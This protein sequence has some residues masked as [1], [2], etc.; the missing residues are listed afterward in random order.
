MRN[1]IK[2][3]IIF[4]F[5]I[6]VF[7]LFKSLYSEHSVVIKDEKLTWN[8]KYKGIEGAKEIAS[9]EKGNFY[10][11]YTDRIQ[12]VDGNGKSFDIIK[13]KD[14]N[15]YS[16]EYKSRKLY[17]SSGSKILCYDLDK[18]QQTQL[19]GDLPNYGDYCNSLIKIRNDELYISIGSATN[20]GVVGSDNF[21]INNSPFNYDI[22]PRDITIRGKSFGNE[23]TGA[24]VPYKTKNVTGQL[25]PG[26]F[27]GNASIIY[28]N[29]TY[30]SADTFSWG[31]RNVKGMAFNSEGKLIAAVGGIEDRGL[32]PVK[33]DVDYIYEIKKELWYGWPD[34]SG[35]DPLTSPRFKGENNSKLSF[36]LDNHP[37]TNP[38]APIYQ[39]KSLS[40]LGSLDVDVKARLGE[41]DCI[42][43][44]DNRDNILYGLTKSGILKEKAAFKKGTAIAS[45]KISDNGLLVLDS[46]NGTLY[47]IQQ[48][49]SSENVKLN[50][51]T[52]YYLIIFIVA[53]III[54]VW[55]TNAGNK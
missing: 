49:S 51:S 50:K 30:N 13:D 43:F 52:I 16:L 11:A 34:Y 14:L 15:I 26:H 22:S 44:Y 38:P 2:I 21:W 39:H 18:K 33:G 46:S 4:G 29:L 45:I 41:K 28:Y 7:V 31:I 27:P 3:I 5:L 1:F 9:D 12:L 47:D 24:F 10:I 48:A 53:S 19:I 54:A 20:S 35:G 8:L 32:R 42:Y 37:S 55:K 25:V 17:Y 40:T 23:K 6:V 36:I